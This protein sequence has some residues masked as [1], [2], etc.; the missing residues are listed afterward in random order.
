MDMLSKN[1]LKTKIKYIKNS[2]RSTTFLLSKVK[3]K[4]TFTKNI[5]KNYIIMFND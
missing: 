4:Y 2:I 1:Y 5:L 3:I